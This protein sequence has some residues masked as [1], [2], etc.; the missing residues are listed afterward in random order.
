[1]VLG[2]HNRA[3]A[4]PGWV[5]GWLPGWIPGWVPGWVPKGGFSLKSIPESDKSIPYIIYQIPNKKI[6]R[7]LFPDFSTLKNSHGTVLFWVN[8]ELSSLLAQ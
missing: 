8:N 5:P 2:H 3:N 1:M 4:V 7:D 6:E